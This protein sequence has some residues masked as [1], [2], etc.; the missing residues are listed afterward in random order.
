MVFRNQTLEFRPTYE[1]LKQRYYKEI[2][3]FITHPLR[4]IGF[5][6]GKTDIFK[7]MP[8]RNAKHLTVVYQKAEVRSFLLMLCCNLN[9]LILL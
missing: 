5:G 4:F 9:F 1:E 6:G 7:V 2:S 8:E 3:M